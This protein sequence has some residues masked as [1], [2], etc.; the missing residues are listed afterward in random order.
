MNLKK[1]ICYKKP[2]Y[3]FHI[4]TLYKKK[5]TYLKN[6]FEIDI[7]TIIIKNP[8]IRPHLFFSRPKNRLHIYNQKN[9]LFA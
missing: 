2:G 7:I 9:V 3:I 1:N 8:I 4:N 5:K 6:Y